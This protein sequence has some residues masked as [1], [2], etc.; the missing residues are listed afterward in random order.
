[1]VALGNEIRNG[2]LWPLG[3]ANPSI[4]DSASRVANFTQLA[5]LWVAA[6]LGITDAVHRGTPKPTAMTHIDNGWDLQLQQNWFSALTGTG[7]VSTA[8]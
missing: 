3:Q 5:T 6:R 2:M 8:D 7:L 1:M 4:T